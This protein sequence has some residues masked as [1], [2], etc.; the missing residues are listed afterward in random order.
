MMSDTV[1]LDKQTGV[2]AAL[3][4]VHPIHIHVYVVTNL[5]TTWA[6]N[7]FKHLVCDVNQNSRDINVAMSAGDR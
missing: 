5:A 1:T 7:S 2:F 3:L 6:W 4:H